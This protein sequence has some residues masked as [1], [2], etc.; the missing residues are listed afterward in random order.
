MCPRGRLCL[1]AKT[2]RPAVMAIRFPSALNLHISLL[3]C[4]H[5][6]QSSTPLSDHFFGFGCAAGVFPIDCETY[7][8][9]LA[10]SCRKSSLCAGVVLCSTLSQMVSRLM[11][12]LTI[13]LAIQAVSR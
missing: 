9:Q 2:S 4:A 3:P 7:K 13:A 12:A 1:L 10:E 5:S 6:P 11:T 8:H